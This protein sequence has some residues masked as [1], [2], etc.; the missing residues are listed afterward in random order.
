VSSYSKGRYALGL[1]EETIAGHRVI[2]HSGGHVGIASELLVVPETGHVAVILTNGDVDA[3]WY[4]RATIARR[5]LG[6]NNGNATYWQTL[7]VIARTEAEGERAGL[8]EA[9]RVG[10]A[11]ALRESVIDVTAGKWLHR[12]DAARALSLLRLNTLLFPAS[13]DAWLRL[14]DSARVLGSVDQAITAYERYLSRV[15]G[16]SDAAVHLKSLQVRASN[17]GAGDT[18]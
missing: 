3:F 16:D 10:G 8:E 2:G 12:D 18:R 4:V 17:A 6:E 1:S 13:D 7:K 14:A 9:E 11:A 5:L 15:P